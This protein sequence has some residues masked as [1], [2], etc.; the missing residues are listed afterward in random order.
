LIDPR[1]LTTFQAVCQAGSISGGARRINL[2]QPSVSLTIAK[3]E[4]ALG[5]PLLERTRTGVEPTPAGAL[6]LARCAS[7]ETLLRDA[8]REIDLA[9]E[10]MIGPLRLGGTPGA[11]VSLVPAALRA[12]EAQGR[13]IAVDIL[14]RPDRELVELLRRGEIEMACVTTEIDP[15]ADGVEE[16]TIARDSYALIVGRANDALPDTISLHDT[17]HLG[18][19][20]PEAQG[21]FRHQVDAL[22][23]SSEVPIPRGAIRCDSLLTTKALVRDS[24][25]V[26]ILPTTVASAEISIGVL[27]AITVREAAF[28]RR[29]GIRKL[30]GARLSA[31][32]EAFLRILQSGP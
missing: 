31:V 19:V 9:G 24:D 25:R 3:L 15:P 17:R 12:M 4:H 16:I 30:H 20:L 18:W 11:L 2:S 14:E 27:R 28:Q 8:E 32:G 5:T 29:V 26:T 22:F 21:A 13:R 7:L 1:A 23:I 10:G 6:L